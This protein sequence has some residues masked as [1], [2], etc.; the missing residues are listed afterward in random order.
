MKADDRRG[1][2]YA[3]ECYDTYRT[4]RQP[5]VSQ[6]LSPNVTEA[7]VAEWSFVPESGGKPENP[8]VQAI[9]ARD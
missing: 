2:D 1:L 6:T 7:T 4:K 8:R 5:A 3:K 9:I